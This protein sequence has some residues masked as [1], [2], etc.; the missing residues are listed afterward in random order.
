MHDYD[1]IVIGAG[2][3]GLVC[4]AYLAKAGQR[5][6]VLERRPVPGGA[7]CTQEDLIP[8]Y[9]IDVGS[10]VH[11]MIHL[12]PVIRELELTEKYGL[13]YIE[14]DP[15]AHYPVLGTDQGISFYRDVDKT[16][17]SIA[18]FSTEDAATYREYVR[19]WT[20]LNEGVFETF[21]QPPTPGRIFSTMLKRNLLGGKRARKVWSSL[22]TSRQLMAPY[23]QVIREY[24]SNE[25]VRTALLWLSAQSGPGPDELASGDMFGWNAMIH[26]S[27][28]WRAR[29]GSG[30]LT[31]A[32]VRC[33]EDHG[34][35]LETDAAVSS[36]GEETPGW[37]VRT[38]KGEWTTRRVI[39]ACHVHTLFGQLLENPPAN[40]SRRVQRTHI[41]NG[42]G[43]ITRHAVEELPQYAPEAEGSAT[44]P[45]HSAMQLLCPSETYLRSSLN[46][47][48]YGKPPE[49]PSVVAMTFS[50]IDPSLAPEGKHTLFTWAQYHPYQ[51]SNGEDWDSIAERE[52][53]KLYDLVCR[54]APNMKGK[55]IDRFIQ[56]P[57]Q[58]EQMHG[59]LRGNVMHLEMS[60]DQMFFFRPLP[61]MAAYKTP[62]KGLYLTGSSTHPGG[63]VFGASGYNTAKVVLRDH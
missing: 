49:N 37:K 32:L 35:K 47:Y 22:D 4:A 48:Q 43:M 16:C 15:W 8:G 5:V 38:E 12:T 63:G 53:D 52:S 26:R 59:L 11:I 27:G 9:R 55:L 40:L 30:S 24:F 31:T 60:L 57:L 39:S 18:E 56:T 46:D 19:H 17:E 1:S 25:H 54:Y 14:M 7:V 21:L 45:Y 33:L 61:E 6:L 62:L 28:A 58:I 42:F 2:H 13:S 20:D 50:A 36:I 51:L 41:G 23:G 3:N 34:G 29:G 10:S 44:R